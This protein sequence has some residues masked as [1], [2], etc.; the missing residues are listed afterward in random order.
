LARVLT[1]AGIA[2]IDVD[3]PD[4]KTRRT[5]GKSDPIDAYAAAPAVL[6]GRAT[7]TPKSRDG[8]VE[9]CACSG[10]RAAA[11]SKPAPRP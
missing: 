10:S 3:R 1:V 4:R 7:G 2:V 5:K 11:P 9:P 6:S 8:V